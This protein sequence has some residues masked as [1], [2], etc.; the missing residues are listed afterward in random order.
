MR[1]M[2]A[3]IRKMVNDGY[4]FNLDFPELK[5]ISSLLRIT[6]NNTNV[7]VSRVLGLLSQ[8]V[9]STLV[10]AKK[11]FEMVQFWP[12]KSPVINLVIGGNIILL[13]T[14]NSENVS[15]KVVFFIANRTRNV[16]LTFR[17]TEKEHEI[18]ERR[19]AQTGIRNMRAYLLKMAIDGYVLQV[20][21]SDVKEFIS[22]LRNATNNINQIAKR[23]NE[24]RNIYEDDIRE[25]QEHVEEIWDK[26]KGILRELS[27]F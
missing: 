23:A 7:A 5:E 12:K 21:L 11:R 8:N 15:K 19:M 22:L 3:Y 1:N 20:D 25:I 18:I 24:T 26:S 4:I 13:K 6:S 10:N 17:V 16:S 2:S 9:L 14:Q 27:K